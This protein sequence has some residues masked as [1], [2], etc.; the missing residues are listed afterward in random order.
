MKIS[1]TSILG[2]VYDTSVPF[3]WGLEEGYDVIAVCGEL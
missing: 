2:C 1:S 3:K